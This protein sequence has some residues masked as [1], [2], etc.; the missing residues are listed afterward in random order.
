M[1]TED[2]RLLGCQYVF[3]KSQPSK[4]Y[5]WGHYWQRQDGTEGG[6]LWIEGGKVIDFDGAFDLPSYVKE[7]LARI[8]L[9]VDW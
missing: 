9:E 6:E 5:P 7:E 4:P 1:S 2:N 3:R 8:G